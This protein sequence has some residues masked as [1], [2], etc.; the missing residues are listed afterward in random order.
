MVL[1][2]A[3]TMFAK[4]RESPFQKK[5][6]MAMNRKAEMREMEAGSGGRG[7]R[8]REPLRLIKHILFKSESRCP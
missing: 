3:G 7:I 6:V 8:E 4:C 1:E 2:A 5:E